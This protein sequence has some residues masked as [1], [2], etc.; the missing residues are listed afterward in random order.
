MNNLKIISKDHMELNIIHNNIN[1]IKPYLII[2]LPFGLPL[3]SIINKIIDF[4]KYFN[5]ITWES[6]TLVDKPINTIKNNLSVENH[7]YDLLAILDY[8][9]IK[10][11]SI[12]GFCSGAGIALA[13]ASTNEIKNRINKLVLICG[14]Y[15]LDSKI[16]KKTSF[17][18]DV[19][20]LLPMAATSLDKA[21][22]LSEY[23]QSGGEYSKEK[24]EF[25]EDISYPFISG[26]RLHLHAINYLEYK[27][28]DFTS[29]ATMVNQPTLLISTLNDIQVD[30]ENSTYISSYLNNFYNHITLNGDHYE[31]LRKNDLMNYHIFNF[32]LN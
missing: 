14:E 22:Q 2:I 28:L 19:D 16:I 12:I 10:T 5:V 9:S 29:T 25:H 26:N 31:F 17:Q 13:S 23:L 27:K 32:I 20:V 18:R 21:I 8:F 11:S 7:V 15:M 30:K 4:D 6:R 1:N 24:T 3:N